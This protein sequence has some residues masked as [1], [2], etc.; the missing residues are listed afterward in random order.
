MGGGVG[1]AGRVGTADGG[2]KRVSLVA[3]TSIITK[4]LMCA[5]FRRFSDITSCLPWTSTVNVLAL[6]LMTL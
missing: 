4:F 6:C 2:G 3:V 1:T 5:G